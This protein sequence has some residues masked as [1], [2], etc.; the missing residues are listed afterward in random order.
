LR[1]DSDPLFA[2]EVRSGRAVLAPPPARDANPAL[3]LKK[4]GLQ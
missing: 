4:Y 3:F 1:W 2:R